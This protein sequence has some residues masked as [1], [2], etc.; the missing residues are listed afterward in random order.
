MP[1]ASTT[2]LFR[3]FSVCSSFKLAIVSNWSVPLDPLIERL[4]IAEYFDAIVALHDV[5]VRSKKPDPHIFNYA[6]AA[7]NVSAEEVVHVGDTYEADIVGARNVGIRPIFIDRDGTQ[8]GR[9]NETIQSLTELLELL[10]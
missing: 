7:V 2:M 3:H 4:G 5:R 10:T 8:T 6:L 9:S 1:L